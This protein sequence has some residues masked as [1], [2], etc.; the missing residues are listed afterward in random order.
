MIQRP[1]RE[2]APNP[3]MDQGLPR[4]TSPG[5]ASRVVS[6]TS[7][8]SACAVPGYAVNIDEPIPGT[9][10]EEGNDEHTEGAMRMPDKEL[11]DA[12]REGRLAGAREALRRGADVIAYDEDHETPLHWAA[13]NGHVEVVRLLLKEGADHAAIDNNDHTPLYRA[14]QN[15][16]ARVA[17]LLLKA[18]ADPAAAGY[19]GITPLHE[20]SRNGHAEVARL[21]LKAGADVNAGT[22]WNA[23]AL[24]WAA[25]QRHADVAR[26]LIESGADP[27]SK[28]SRGATPLNLAEDG[29]R[30]NPEI[31]R[32]LKEA[33]GQPVNSPDAVKGQ[34]SDFAGRFKRQRAKGGDLPE[35]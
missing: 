1:G 11:F 23:S 35:H 4:A 26:L 10:P 20:A 16:H 28:N 18:G 15:G 12:A 33:D 30:E 6:E 34:A 22:D 27:R 29:V 2:S 7:H 5:H 8:F 31:I 3:A 21:L 24:H 32:L 19:N 25:E 13:K 17:Q 14:A 9:M